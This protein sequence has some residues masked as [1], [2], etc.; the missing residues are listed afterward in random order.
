M[1]AVG[2]FEAKTHLSEYVARAEAGEEIV[3]TRHNRPVAKIV[4]IGRSDDSHRRDRAR[5]AVR[6]LLEAKRRWQS[7]HGLASAGLSVA[8]V[9]AL[10]E[11]R[12]DDVEPSGG[13]AT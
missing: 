12:A 6:A 9:R 4:P 3:I 8:L 7:E 13:T 11:G 2:L 5:N 10:R 1:S